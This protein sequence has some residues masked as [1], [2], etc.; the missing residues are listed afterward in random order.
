MGVPSKNAGAVH[1]WGPRQKGE[2]VILDNRDSF[3][4]NLAHRCSE[5][6]VRPAVIRSD[7]ATIEDL[8]RRQ[9]AGLIISP[10][11]GHPDDAGCSVQ[12]VRH[13]SGRIPMLGV[14]LGHQ[15]IAVAFGGEVEA[16]GRPVHGMASR[17]EHGATGLFEGLPHNFSA[18]RYHSLVV[19]AVPAE[20]EATAWADGFVMAVRHKQWPIYGIQFHPESVLTPQGTQLLSNFCELVTP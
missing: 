13:F 11:P 5:V 8:K 16:N 12:A 3:V 1:G 18:A 14:C 4:F 17:I 20:L 6:G 9:P 10:G 19:S 2:L 15:V 7:E